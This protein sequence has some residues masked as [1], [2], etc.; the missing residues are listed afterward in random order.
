MASVMAIGATGVAESGAKDAE[1]IF[2]TKV[3]YI[4]LFLHGAKVGRTDTVIAV[5][6]EVPFKFGRIR[7]N[8]YVVGAIEPSFAVLK[9]VFAQLGETE[10]RFFIKDARSS[11]SPEHLKLAGPVVIAV[12]NREAHRE[13]ELF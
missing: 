12:G 5:G 10:D 4:K 3:Q 7:F 11:D 8:Q 2:F 13:P 1:K 9:D 6:E